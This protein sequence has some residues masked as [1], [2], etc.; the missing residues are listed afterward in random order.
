[1]NTVF[2]LI[3]TTGHYEHHTVSIPVSESIMRELKEPMECSNE[4]ISMLLASMSS[5]RED[6]GQMR[7]RK[8]KMRKDIAREIANALTEA[9]VD[10]F[11]NGDTINGYRKDK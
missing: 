7:E 5:P 2:S 11:G 9:L 8:F 4:P 10:Y 6:F 1:M 3:I